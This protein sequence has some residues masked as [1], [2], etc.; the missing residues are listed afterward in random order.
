[1]TNDLRIGIAYALLSGLLWGFGPLFL[2]RGMK[3]SD[4]S[5]ATLIQQ[6]V[7]VTLLGF[8]ATFRGELIEL[9]FSG[10]AFWSFF[11]TGAVGASFGKIFYYKG[12]DKLGA[13]KST[14]VKNASPFLTAI[15]A[16]L[17]LGEEV[18]GY[19]AAGIALIVLGI[20]VLTRTAG[21]AGGTA[22]GVKYYIYPLLAAF[23]F[24]V[25]P[26]FK[27]VGIT[28]A[29]VPVLGAFITQTTALVF[30]LTIGRF[31]AIK[32][33]WQPVPMMALS[34]F[35]LSGITEALGSL[36]TFFALSHAPAVL[37]SPM[38]RISP[39]VTFALA[40]F[41]LRGI[42]IV[43]LRDGVAAALIVFGV[44]VLSQG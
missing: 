34:L 41:T 21:K 7:A 13:S 30:M 3:H 31:L 28:A 8:L 27:K 39:L 12:I 19:I 37:V 15:L 29:N 36:F 1:M 10:R 2:K 43:T 44:F 35:I 20:V 32:P 33:A 14:S 5:A 22:G 23:C 11:L 18:N 38:W 6:V 17:F 26:I 25:N 4:V 24:G 42:E 40:H 9:D 16:A